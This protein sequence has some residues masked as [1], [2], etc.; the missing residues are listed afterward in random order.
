[1]SPSRR[2]VS[3]GRIGGSEIITSVFGKLA[4][5]GSGKKKAKKSTH[6]KKAAAHQHHP[7]EPED[8]DDDVEEKADGAG[9]GEGVKE[10]PK[11]TLMTMTKT[12][13]AMDSEAVSTSVQT[14][15]RGT[16][17]KSE[18]DGYTDTSSEEEAAAPADEDDEDDDDDG[19][20]FIFD[21]RSKMSCELAG[22]RNVCTWEEFNHLSANLRFCT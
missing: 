14:T 17:S 4:R 20:F 21:L 7:G 6:H 19:G 8:F 13:S 3:Q 2:V 12:N 1:V 22:S 15:P 10:K 5:L 11:I 18:L 9:E 16:E